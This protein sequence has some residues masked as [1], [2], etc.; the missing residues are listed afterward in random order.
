MQVNKIAHEKE[1]LK[2]KRNR[3]NKKLKRTEHQQQPASSWIGLRLS[4]EADLLDYAAEA[5]A[6]MHNEVREYRRKNTAL[7][8]AK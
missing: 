3:Q 8:V 7:P 5:E 4:C 2:R 6:H 1:I